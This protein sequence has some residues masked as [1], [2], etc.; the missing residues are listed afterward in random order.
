MLYANGAAATTRSLPGQARTMRATRQ[1]RTLG[2]LAAVNTYAF[3]LVS[4][5][6][7]R[8]PK[9]S[10]DCTAHSDLPVLGVLDVT[11][12]IPIGVADGYS[13]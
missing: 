12:N 2:G 11:G 4:G 5:E 13:R 1:N 9:E 8:P 10:D 3:L 6:R 7:Q